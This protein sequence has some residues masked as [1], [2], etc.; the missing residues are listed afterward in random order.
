MERADAPGTCQNGTARQ[1]GFRHRLIENACKRLLDTIVA[2]AALFASIL[3]MVAIWAVLKMVQ[4]GPTIACQARIGRHGRPFSSL[5]FRTTAGEG[6]DPLAALVGRILI[7]TGLNELP[8]LF[9]VLRGTMSLVGPRPI[10]SSEMSHYG[11]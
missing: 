10:A 8:E 3:L 6:A 1:T 5:R 11:T 7:R 4:S 9:N 2:A